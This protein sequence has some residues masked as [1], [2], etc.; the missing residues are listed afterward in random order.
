MM[1]FTIIFMNKTQF[2]NSFWRMFFTKSRMYSFFPCLFKLRALFFCDFWRKIVF[3]M[4]RNTELPKI[5]SF[6]FIFFSFQKSPIKCIRNF[7]TIYVFTFICF[8]KSIVKPLMKSAISN[9]VFFPCA[10]LVSFL[11]KMLTSW[12]TKTSIWFIF[13]VRKKI[14]KRI[15]AYNTQLISYCSFCPFLSANNRTKLSLSFAQFIWFYIKFFSTCP[16]IFVHKPK[17]PFRA[18]LV[19]NCVTTNQA[20]NGICNYFYR[21]FIIPNFTF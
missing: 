16:A 2:S 9:C 13:F 3:S 10:N 12:R 6:P 8:S 11:I 17:T 14:S 20:Q 4:T 7:I 1:A 18:R 19:S 5:L 21:I 15:I